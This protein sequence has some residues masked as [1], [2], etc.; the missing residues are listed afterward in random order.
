ME[1][2]AICAL[3]GLVAT[4]WICLRLLDH[5]AD[6]QVSAFAHLFGGYR[7]DGWPVG[8]QEEDR[9]R[10][11]GTPSAPGAGD[12]EEASGRVEVSRLEPAIR[13]RL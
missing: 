12:D 6:F 5:S 13:A 11:W 1:L 3:G 4:T 9:D 10:P 7:P 2:L 8:V